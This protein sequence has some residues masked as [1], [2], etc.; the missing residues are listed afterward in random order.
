MTQKAQKDGSDE[1]GW[2]LDVL[3]EFAE[4]G[5]LGKPCPSAVARAHARLLRE[6]AELKEAR[7]AYD[8]VALAMDMAEYPEGQGGLHVA[9]PEELIRRVKE[10][11]RERDQF[12]EERD[13]ARR[14]AWRLGSLMDE[15][16]RWLVLNEDEDADIS[17]ALA[18]PEAKP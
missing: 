14:V 4:T 2:A 7:K 5:E 6:R 3:V 18:Y 15:E 9:S 10:L 8:D 17:T 13:E 12:W 11:Q 1:L 16:R